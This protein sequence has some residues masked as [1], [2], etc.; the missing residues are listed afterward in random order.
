MEFNRIDNMRREQ[1]I[2]S[3]G[4]R[5][6][7]VTQEHGRIKHGRIACWYGRILVGMFGSLVSMFGSLVGMDESLVSMEKSIALMERL[8]FI[9]NKLIVSMDGSSGKITS[10]GRQ[11]GD[12]N[13][14]IAP[15]THAERHQ[16]RTI[17][18]KN[19]VYH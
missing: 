8:I 9:M 4:S 17:L 16:S 2:Q 5:L 6:C 19:R 10:W 11:Q 13:D 1:G 3:Q 12:R 18:E 14:G 15:F 7:K